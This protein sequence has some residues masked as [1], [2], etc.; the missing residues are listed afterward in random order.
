MKLL[1]SKWLYK[2]VLQ[3][4]FQAS[5][6][7]K[8][9]R[10]ILYKLF[11]CLMLVVWIGENFD[12]L[13]AMTDGVPRTALSRQHEKCYCS[14]CYD[15]HEGCLCW[16]NLD[17]KEAADS[18]KPVAAT[19]VFYKAYNCLPLESGGMLL[20]PEMKCLLYSAST[21]APGFPAE[22]DWPQDIL[23]FLTDP[24]TPP[25]FHPPET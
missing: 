4:I 13:A 19:D 20:A 18:A 2:T 16:K 17:A 3:I 24:F 14:D 21:L 9:R 1:V 23:S 5:R 12:F 15:S 25:I 8:M 11:S 7:S 10:N 6:L 22:S